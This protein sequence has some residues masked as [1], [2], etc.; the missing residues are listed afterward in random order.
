MKR[1][2]IFLVLVMAVSMVIT[3]AA[4]AAGEGSGGGAGKPLEI[5]S[6]SISDGETD[7]SLDREIKFV[8]SKN[9]AN[10]SVAENNRNCFTMTDSRGNAVPIEVIT[11]DDQLESEKK[12]DII[13]RPEALQ[14]AE[15]YTITISPDLQAKNGDKLGQE[16]KY[17]FSTVGYVP[18]EAGNTE[19]STQLWLYLVVIAVILVA[20]FI[21][22]KGKKNGKK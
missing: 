17:T 19:S 1:T 8:F 3:A 10:I 21:F 9:I 18:A 11:F 14:E 20:A 6:C 22:I 16:V 15:Q 7:V 5:V 12:N 2:S 4:W 13:V